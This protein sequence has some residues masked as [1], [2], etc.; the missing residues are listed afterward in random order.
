MSEKVT[1]NKKRIAVV[2]GSNKGIGWEIANKLCHQGLKCILACRNEE[3]GKQAADDFCAQ[4]YDA[5]YRNCDIGSSQNIDQ[6]VEGLREDYQ[7]IHVLVNNAGTAFK[8]DDSTPFKDQAEPTMH[9]N[10]FG[11][12]ELTRKMLPLLRAASDP[13]IVSVASQAGRLDIFKDSR[14]RSQI[15]RENLSMQELEHLCS[16]F[17]EDVK[18]E[19]HTENGWPDTCYGMSKAAVIA[20]T[21]ILARDNPDITINAC[22]PGKCSTEMTSHSG[23]SPEEGARVAAYLATLDRQNQAGDRP[24]GKFFYDMHEIEW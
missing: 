2:T 23:R 19:R 24:T 13:I 16:E 21:K 7:C 12:L 4:G 20:M 10:F 15:S 17:I 6:F 14:R 9:T 11:T 18:A 8:E 22:C 3:E 5:E 1:K